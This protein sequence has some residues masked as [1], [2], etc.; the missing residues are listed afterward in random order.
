MRDT[1]PDVDKKI[2]EMLQS[3]SPKKRMIMGCSLY[4]FAKQLVVNSLLQDD[5]HLSQN[6]LRRELFL[7]FYGNEFDSTRRSKIIE[8]LLREPEP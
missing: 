7:R 6:V 3:R 5:P 2:Q 8:Y 4:D 1:P